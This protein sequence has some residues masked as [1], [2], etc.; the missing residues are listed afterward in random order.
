MVRL[1]V[2]EAVFPYTIA[3]FEEDIDASSPNLDL[4]GAGDN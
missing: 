2:F 1:N 3:V 4:H